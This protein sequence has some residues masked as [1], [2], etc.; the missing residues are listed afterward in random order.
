MEEE[1]FLIL[2]F[3]EEIRTTA[4]DEGG[5]MDFSLYR[6]YIFLGLGP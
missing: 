2:W 5:K 6:G 3:R 1:K 4:R